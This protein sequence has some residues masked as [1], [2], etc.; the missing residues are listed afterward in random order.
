[1]TSH[2]FCILH[3]A[4]CILQFLVGTSLTL[5]ETN[6]EA[7]ERDL[8]TRVGQ[9]VRQLD[10][11]K[12]VDRNAA[13]EELVRLGPDVLALLPQRSD[14]S[15]EVELRLSRV[16]LAL[17]QAA[18][19]ASVQQPSRVTLRGDA[20]PLSKVL[21]AFG[22]Q[23]QNRIVDARQGG[24][25]LTKSSYLRVDFDKTP[26]WQA[27]DQVLDQAGLS[28]DLFGDQEAARI[29]SRDGAEAS[30]SKRASYA[31]PFRFEVTSVMAQRDLRNPANRVL[32]LEME[33]AWEPRLRPIAFQHR[34]AD[35][36]AIDDRGRP[37][38]VLTPQADLEVPVE[39]GPIA[40]V[41]TIP[42]AMPPREVKTIA[43]LHGTLRAL[44]PAHAE[45]FRF[46]GLGQ[47]ARVEKRIA[48]VTVTLEPV[49]KGPKGW[50]V[51]ILV[52]FDR[53]QGALASHRNW[54]FANPAYLEHRDGRRI[55]PEPLPETT[56]RDAA[57]VGVRYTF[58]V[59]GP[60][61]DYAFV[62]QTPTMIVWAR[63]EYEVKEIP[64]P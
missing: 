3:F 18:A 32:R 20:V 59:D 17:Q 31:G 15:R 16:R 24:G 40:K 26:F 5:S 34:L 45:S 53:A 47:A 63:L 52:R 50:E 6:A 22:E 60:I 44:V 28:I 7:T 51:P 29:V 19:E 64:L 33:V 23:T 41:L 42:L 14:A 37:L 12:L 38:A 9:L 62:Y 49:R 11:P 54:I 56:Q 43:R 2:S 25:R 8:A 27:M 61:K 13:E 57:E 58:S 4:F 30:R 10:A 39:R 21:A 35:V 46:E 55:A 36:T 1:V 48:G